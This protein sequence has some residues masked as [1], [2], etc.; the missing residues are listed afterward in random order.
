MSSKLPAT[1]ELD[2]AYLL[3]LMPPLHNIE[4][5]AW[6]PELFSIIGVEKLVLLCRYAG[7]ES[8]KIPTIDQLNNSIDALQWFYDIRVK[9]TKQAVEVPTHLQNLVIKIAEVYDARDS[10]ANNQ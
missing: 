3:E 8:I 9:K 1:E 5:F 4:E 6:L 7:G 10:K 2:F